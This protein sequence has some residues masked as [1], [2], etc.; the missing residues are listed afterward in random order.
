MSKVIEEGLTIEVDDVVLKYCCFTW[1]WR[2]TQRI[3][4][5]LREV[6]PLRHELSK[7]LKEHHTFSHILGG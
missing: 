1:A 2:V 7:A 3:L 4:E 6:W 5:G